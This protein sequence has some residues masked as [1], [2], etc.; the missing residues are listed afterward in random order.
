MAT[1]IETR[2]LGHLTLACSRVQPPRFAGRAE[3]P[4]A[5]WVHH[6]VPVPL[7]RSMPGSTSDCSVRSRTALGA[8]ALT[9]H[10]VGAASDDQRYL[11]PSRRHPGPGASRYRAPPCGLRRAGTATRGPG[12]RYVHPVTVSCGGTI[13]R[14]G[15]TLG[16]RRISAVQ[17]PALTGGSTVLRRS[18]LHL[19]SPRGTPWVSTQVCGARAQAE[20]IAGD[21]WVL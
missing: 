17:F 2:G 12:L 9:L 21:P 3:V 6:L 15:P 14:A 13:V 11:R 8:S 1:E 19:A 18:G 10:R 5:H 16:V 4:T 7:H 20:P